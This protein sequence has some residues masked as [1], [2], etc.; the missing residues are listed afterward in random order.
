[1]TLGGFRLSISLRLFGSSVIS[2]NYSLEWVL[3]AR[4]GG[5]QHDEQRNQSLHLKISD[6]NFD[7]GGTPLILS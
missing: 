3:P 6:K 1:M 5:K 4:N 2:I 7:P